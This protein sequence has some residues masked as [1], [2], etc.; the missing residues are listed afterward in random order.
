MEYLSMAANAGRHNNKALVSVTFTARR[1]VGGSGTERD[2]QKVF[3]YICF[4]SSAPNCETLKE[5][6]ELKINWRFHT[7][8]KMVWLV[9]CLVCQRWE[10][11]K[12]HFKNDT[13]RW[14]DPRPAPLRI[15][16]QTVSRFNTCYR[17]YR[18]LK[19]R[20]WRKHLGLWWNL[21]IQ[22]VITVLYFIFLLFIHYRR[23]SALQLHA[24][25]V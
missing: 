24:W 11:K 3:I 13:E 7:E 10:R 15:H 14:A 6:N 17:H 1:S 23:D 22:P 20:H 21:S 4:V 8:G 25:V 12:R 19:K 5:S 9:D 2:T 16:T 18:R